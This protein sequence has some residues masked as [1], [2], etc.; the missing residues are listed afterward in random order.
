MPVRRRR[1]PA[2]PA[3]AARRLALLG[4]GLAIAIAFLFT[5]LS[6][7]RWPEYRFLRRW[8]AAHP[9]AATPFARRDAVSTARPT[10]SVASV[11]RRLAAAVAT[12]A[13]APTIYDGAYVTLD[14]PGGDVTPDRGV[15]T[16]LVVRA[17]RDIGIDLQRAVHE[18][19]TADF[20]AYPTIWGSDAPNAN[21]D[22]RRVP[23]LMVFF[24]RAGA[25]RPNSVDAADY[26][27]GDVIAWQLGGG[28]T[29]IGIL[30]DR[31]SDDGLRPLVAHHIG[32]TPVVADFLFAR[33]VIGH[34]RYP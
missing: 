28:M 12:R 29:H 2:G 21:I 9:A 33:P 24:T 27:P 1:P 13:A 14:Y 10:P 15:C 22:H 6:A 18:D 16:D 19:M 17:F 25:A 34:F 30:T 4:A 11:H 7:R 5:A 26:L 31:Y 3:R 23:N 8:D 32:G 20:G